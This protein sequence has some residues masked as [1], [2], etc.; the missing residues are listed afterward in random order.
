MEGFEALALERGWLKRISEDA[1]WH[2]EAGETTR[3][4]VVSYLGAASFTE[5]L[6][7]AAAPKGR[8]ILIVDD[9]LDNRLLAK[10]TLKAEGYD[11]AEAVDGASALE[12][13]KAHKPDLV[14]LDLMMPGVDGFAVI[15]SLRADPAT[16]HLPVIVLTALSDAESQAVSLELGA[17][18]YM[19]KPFHPKILRARVQAL[20]RRRDCR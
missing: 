15:R 4:E 8:R 20:F 1:L 3:D 19:T 11:L 17:D 16:A 7:Q 13:V 14:L 5:A 2:L 12:E 10:D 9:S 6:P 18:D